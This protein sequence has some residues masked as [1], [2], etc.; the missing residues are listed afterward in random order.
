MIKAAFFAAGA[1]SILISALIVIS[2]VGRAIEFL[3][4][5][6]LGSLWGIGWFPRRGLFDIR[7]IIVGTFLI[8]GI[9]M[10]VAAPIGLGGLWLTAFLWPRSI[11]RSTP[12][13]GFVGSS[14]RSS[15]SWPECPAWSWGSSPSR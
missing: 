4:Q 8:S 13:R 6:D 2:L 3:R 15:R 7:T 5:V 11:S 9:A 12:H 14:N 1:L 10:A